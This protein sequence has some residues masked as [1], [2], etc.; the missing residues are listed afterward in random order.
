LSDAGTTGSV[1]R[2]DRVLPG[3]PWIGLLA[4]ALVA[5]RQ[6]LAFAFSDGAA[7]SVEHIFF[8]AAENPPWL[9]AIVAAALLASR[10]R[11]LR[12]AVGAPG[13]PLLAATL[14]GPGVVLLAWARFV[15]APDLAL[16]GT[17]GMMLGAAYAAAGGRLARLIALPVLLLVFAVPVPGVIVNE[18]VYPLQLATAKYAYGILT[19]IGITSVRSADVI[20]TASH[21]FI[22]IEGCS[23]LGSMEVLTLLALAWGWETNAPL[24]RGAA[25]ALAAPV[26]AFVLNGFRVVTLVLFPDNPVW[27]GH[28]VQGVVTFAIGALCIAALDRLLERG[29]QPAAPRPPLAGPPAPKPPRALVAWLALAAVLSLAVPRYALPA[30]EASG[31]LLPEGELGPWKSS[32]AKVDLMFLGSIRFDRADRRVYVADPPP[33]GTSPNGEPVRVEAFVGESWRGDRTLSLRSEKNCI[34]GRGWLVEEKAVIELASGRK[35]EHAV[36]RSE[37]RRLVSWTYYTGLDSPW[38]EAARSFLALDRS[39]FRR[40]DYAHVVRL[41]TELLPSERDARSAERRLRYLHRAIEPYLDQHLADVAAA[42]WRVAFPAG[43]PGS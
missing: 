16:L 24:W 3:A 35:A 7:Q 22:V 11:D 28:T 31:A 14:L 18:I 26:I 4:L 41:S 17:L 42:T 23:G 9:L 29:P 19:S 33:P 39:P 37:S 1:R 13:R 27:S 2:L 6:G 25:L 15:D 12:D 30:L 38:I 21:A 36:A 8:D 34:P 43:T 10:A 32:P 20:R 40:V 5:W